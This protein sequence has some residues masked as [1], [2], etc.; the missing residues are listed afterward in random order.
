MSV[1]SV[2]LERAFFCEAKDLTIHEK[3]RVL[4]D[5]TISRLDR[6]LARLSHYP[7]Y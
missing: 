2:I 4:C 3:R 1:C 6:F 7:K 5:A